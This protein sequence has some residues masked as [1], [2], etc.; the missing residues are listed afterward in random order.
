[1]NQHEKTTDFNHFKAAEC[2]VGQI[3]ALLIAIGHAVEKMDET[4][5]EQ[6]I[7]GFRALNSTLYSEF[8]YMKKYETQQQRGTTSAGASA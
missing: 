1:M 3:E 2:R 8:E 7:S 5:L 6:A 4:S